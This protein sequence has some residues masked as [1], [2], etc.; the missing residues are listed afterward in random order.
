LARSA[1]RRA[2]N[3]SETVLELIPPQDAW[4]LVGVY[5]YVVSMMPLRMRMMAYVAGFA[6]QRAGAADDRRGRGVPVGFQADARIALGAA[7]QREGGSAMGCD[8]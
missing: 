7:V 3:E 2:Y 6:R 4:A 8:S 5:R 1:A